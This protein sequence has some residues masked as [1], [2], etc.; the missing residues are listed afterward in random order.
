MSIE[1]NKAVIRRHFEEIRNQRKDELIEEVSDPAYQVNRPDR[2]DFPPGVAGVAAMDAAVRTDFPDA[3]FTIEDM[4]AEGD[5]VLTFLDAA[6]HAPGGLARCA[7]DRA[8]GGPAG[9]HR[10]PAGRRADRRALRRGGVPG[11]AAP[12]GRHPRA[13]AGRRLR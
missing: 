3:Q 5:R 12:G 8:P 4:L 7:P 2:P 6:G 1:A 9:Q 13:P 10:P 11:R